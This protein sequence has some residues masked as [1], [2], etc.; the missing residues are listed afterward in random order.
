[1][2]DDLVHMGI[3]EPYRMFT[4]RAERRLLL[5]QDNAFLRL[6]DRAYVLG[7]INEA[8]YKDFC[9]EKEAIEQTINRLKQTYSQQ[10]LIQFTTETCWKNVIAREASTKLSNRALLTV[11]ASFM[12]E[13]YLKREQQEIARREQYKEVALPDTLRIE[14]L[15][16]LSKELQEKMLKYKPATIADAALIPGMTPAAISLLIFKIREITRK[17][18]NKRLLRT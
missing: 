9:V 4:S 16:G 15:P 17:S 1:M 11:R 18:R 6:T 2:V 5:R 13:P 7:L 10:Q 8:V 14:D 3:D 12:Y